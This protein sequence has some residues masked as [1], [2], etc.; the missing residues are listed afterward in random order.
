MTQAPSNQNAIAIL[1]E[2]EDSQWR[3]QV[4]VLAGYERGREAL[5]GVL[6]QTR[7]L[8]NINALIGLYFERMNQWNEIPDHIIPTWGVEYIQH[9]ETQVKIL[10][11]EVDKIEARIERFRQKQKQS[12]D[13]KPPTRPPQTY[14]QPNG[15]YGS[16]SDEG[17]TEAGETYVLFCN[18]TE[19][20]KDDRQ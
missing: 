10:N 16:E 8:N 5:I 13:R 6:C 3:S 9:S 14:Y 11:T 12:I 7:S 4:Q 19:G 1:R 18:H 15:N 2:I 17:A 20:N